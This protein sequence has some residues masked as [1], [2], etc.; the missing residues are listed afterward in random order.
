[1]SILL[2]RFWKDTLKPTVKDLQNFIVKLME[3]KIENKRKLCILKKESYRSLIV[4]FFG[5]NPGVLQT[6]WKMGDWIE[7]MEKQEYIDFEKFL[8]DFNIDTS[9]LMGYKLVYLIELF[10]HLGFGDDA[11][12]HIQ[13]IQNYI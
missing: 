11:T 3:E 10:E 5:I 13:F 4:E 9:E 6:S 2:K 12:M 1:M 7:W 8:Q